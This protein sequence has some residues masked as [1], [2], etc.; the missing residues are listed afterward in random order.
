VTVVKPVVWLVWELG[1]DDRMVW[2]VYSTP[3]LAETVAHA[4]GGPQAPWIQP[5]RMDSV[6]GGQE[7]RT[8][9]AAQL[10]DEE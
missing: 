6:P 1:D 2:G 10:E 3:E 5:I 8:C 7:W 9:P 4:K